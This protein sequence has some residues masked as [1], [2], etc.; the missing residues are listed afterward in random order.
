MNAKTPLPNQ[1]PFFADFTSFC[2]IKLH[3]SIPECLVPGLRS[4]PSAEWS[5][6]TGD[7]DVIVVICEDFVMLR[8]WSRRGVLPN[9]GPKVRNTTGI[10]KLSTYSSL[11][12][13]THYSN[14][15]PPST[16]RF[17][18]FTSKH[19]SQDCNC[20]RESP[21]TPP[22]KYHAQYSGCSGCNQ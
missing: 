16:L 12:S 4:S 13:P 22:T 3:T 19:G 6:R 1:V 15:L 11:F 14:S 9:F 8:C 7:V 5:R 17:Y 2:C 21:I 20:L 18:Q 10:C